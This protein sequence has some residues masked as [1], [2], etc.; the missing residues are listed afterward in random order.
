MNNE[1]IILLI[2]F[3]CNNSL[4]ILL[5]LLYVYYIIDSSMYQIFRCWKET[6]IVD[7]KGWVNIRKSSPFP[8]SPTM[9][10]YL[11]ECARVAGYSFRSISIF[12]KP[13]RRHTL[14]IDV[15]AP[16]SVMSPNVTLA[17][18]FAIS[19]SAKD[20]SV[21]SSCCRCH[22]RVQPCRGHGTPKLPRLLPLPLPPLFLSVVVR[23][24]RLSSE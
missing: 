17:F 14:P 7:H 18:I 21:S 4:I 8:P 1:Y 16:S 9:F 24:A 23:G 22:D 12:L 19:F 15:H 10:S 13:Y 2:Y 6:A 5:C 11:I 3:Y 20:E